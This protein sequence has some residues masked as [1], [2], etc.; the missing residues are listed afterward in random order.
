[1]TK[2]ELFRE[3]LRAK[4]D[5]ARIGDMAVLKSELLGYRARPDLDA[6][7]RA[8]AQPCPEVD[9]EGLGRL[10]RG[11]LGREYAE[12]LAANR[13]SPF[14]LTAALDPGVRERQVFT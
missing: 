4:R 11:T 3:L 14:R 2:R 5:P 13:L 8:M 12:L 9:L 10:P 1:M 7:L 6:K